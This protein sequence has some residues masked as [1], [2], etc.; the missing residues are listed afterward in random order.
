[1]KLI[2]KLMITGTFCKIGGFD[3]IAFFFSYYWN[4]ENRIIAYSR[5]C[6]C[7]AIVDSWFD[8]LF[9]RESVTFVCV[10]YCVWFVRNEY[11]CQKQQHKSET[12][13]LAFCILWTFNRIADLYQQFVVF[14]I[15]CIFSSIYFILWKKNN[16]YRKYILFC[17]EQSYQR[18]FLLLA[19]LLF[20][21]QFEWS[22][23]RH[24]KT[25]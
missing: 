13:V 14:F 15:I 24:W 4:Y 17:V 6:I 25:T 10:V 21:E 5:L 2:I 23:F 9:R 7:I 8:S 11:C 19:A 18:R 22:L 1:M 3:G 12:N 20:F 16:C